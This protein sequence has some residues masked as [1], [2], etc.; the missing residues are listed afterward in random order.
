MKTLTTKDIQ[1]KKDNLQTEFDQI[2]AKALKCE[3]VIAATRERLTQH[4]QEMQSLQGGYK[5]ILELEAE[6]S[7]EKEHDET[8]RIQG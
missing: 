4:I 3:E 6:L 1:A 5:A 8:D 7:E 2:K